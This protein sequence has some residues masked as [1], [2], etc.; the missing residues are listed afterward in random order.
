M[1]ADGFARIGA[2]D[3]IGKSDRHRYLIVNHALAIARKGIRP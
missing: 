2:V 1:R 3:L